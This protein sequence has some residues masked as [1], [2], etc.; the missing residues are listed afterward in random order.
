MRRIRGSGLIVLLVI[1]FAGVSVAQTSASDP[2]LVTIDSG[3]VRGAAAGEVISFKGIPYA[4]LY[5][6]CL[7]RCSG[8]AI[9]WRAQFLQVC[10]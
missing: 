2:T 9:V 3:T 1:A 8:G 7:G 6:P 10:Q 5:S 4:E